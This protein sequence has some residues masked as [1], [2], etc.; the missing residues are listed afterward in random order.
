ML[1]I[2]DVVTCNP[3]EIT[4]QHEKISDTGSDVGSA[5]CS[6]DEKDNESKAAT[7]AGEG[8]A[9][10]DAGGDGEEDENGEQLQE[11][12]FEIYKLKVIQLA[13]ALGLGEELKV[14]EMKSGGF[15]DI[16][17]LTISSWGYPRNPT[18]DLVLRISQFM[19]ESDSAEFLDQIA[20]TS[21]LSRYDFLHVPM[22][23]G[24]DSTE[25][26]ALGNVYVLQERLPGV[27]A[28][29]IFYKLP[30]AE[31]LQITTLVAETLTKLESIK[32]DRPGRLAAKFPLPR[33]LN[34]LCAPVKEIDIAPYR[35]SPIAS[36]PA[37]EQQPLP[38]YF[39]TLFEIQKKRDWVV[40]PRIDK[41]MEIAKE[42]ESA[43]FMRTTDTDNILWHWD[44][45]AS[46]VMLHRLDTAN[47]ADVENHVPSHGCQH[48]VEIKVDNEN[49]PG[50]RHA[51]QVEVKD[52]A[53]KI[54]KHKIE[55]SV[56]HSSS[57][58]YRHTIN[59]AEEARS[60]GFANTIN[61]ISS[62]LPDSNSGQWVLG[63]VLDWDDVLSVPRVLARKPPSWLWCA[64][65][66]RVWTQNRDEPPPRDLSQD[67]LLIKAHFD[68]LMEKASPGYLEDTYYRG[69]WLRR[70]ARFA[71]EG[72]DD[73]EAY[74]RHDIF[75]KEWY[76]YSSWLGRGIK[77]DV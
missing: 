12:S 44:F 68:Q 39:A 20:I 52:N 56:E 6:D 8:G 5:E 14:E 71:L 70:L 63:G 66:D 33:K 75:V 13:Q 25:N 17:G 46:N 47:L 55:I 28:A 18:R 37:V 49:T 48:K 10:S 3:E 9:G 73:G 50:P 58:I 23:I 59:I 69:I 31:K 53:G 29:D 57:K 51:I 45:S 4:T 30:L 36:F 65:E 1:G 32:F 2:P 64:E 34:G 67:E 77:T 21:W 7:E 15:N 41:L 60:G 38:N 54:C 27:P 22:I 26:N 11:E 42:M 35:H 61:S 43:G 72:F 62:L 76:E 40:A 74:K 16:V 19:D 24:Y